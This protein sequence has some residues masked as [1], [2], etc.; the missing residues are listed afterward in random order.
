M[1]IIQ[2][3]DSVLLLT[4]SGITLGCVTLNIR[5]FRKA[6]LQRKSFS[7]E[8]KYNANSVLNRLPDFCEEKI[9]YTRR[10]MLRPYVEELCENLSSEDLK[11]V[12]ENFKTLSVEKK[13]KLS[14]RHVI[15]TYSHFLNE[16]IYANKHALG[17]EFLHMASS[18]YDKENDINFFGFKQ[19][20]DNNIIGNALN[21]GYTELLNVRFYKASLDEISYFDEV[22]IAA[23]LEL[24]FDSEKEMTHLYFSCDLPGFIKHFEKYSPREEIIKLIVDM[25]DY[26]IY[27]THNADFLGLMK[28]VSIYQRI[29][30]WFISKNSNYEKLKRLEQ[31]INEDRLVSI[32]VKKEKLKLYRD[33]ACKEEST[34]NILETK[35]KILRK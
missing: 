22:K 20:D 31:L 10:E 28:L 13:D 33:F 18:T 35:K 1:D 5:A 12:C 4:Y 29:Y 30:K 27:K 15:G 32:F 14:E 2:I 24:F 16:I 25:D 23:M 3:I 26:M 11:L 7:G 8:I 9:N 21:E 34:C 17:H 6:K 19:T